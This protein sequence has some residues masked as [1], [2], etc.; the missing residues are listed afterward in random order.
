VLYSLLYRNIVTG[1]VSR[2]SLG[3]LDDFGDLR[4]MLWG[5]LVDL[6][7]TLGSGGI[8]GVV[9]LGRPWWGI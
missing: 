9:F 1:N 6:G 4:G 2:G 3:T 8:L 7:G 5:L